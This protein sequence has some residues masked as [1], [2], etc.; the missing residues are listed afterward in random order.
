M[1]HP[2][3]SRSLAPDG[4]CRRIKTAK[5]TRPSYSSRTSIVIHTTLSVL[6]GKPYDTVKAWNGGRSP[7]ESRPREM[8]QAP[9]LLLFSEGV[10]RILKI[11]RHTNRQPR[12]RIFRLARSHFSS[13]WIAALWI[14]TIAAT[15][16]ADCYDPA[17]Q[18]ESPFW[19]PCPITG[20]K[21]CCAF[22]N[23]DLCT[24]GGLCLNGGRYWRD[25]CTDPTWQDPGCVKLCLCTLTRENFSQK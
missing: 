20:T 12:L 6:K 7:L 14:L 22:G 1:A 18:D 3:A 16:T 11:G 21:M 24:A 23:G 4:C 8:A 13:T 5:V 17:G 25:G 9:P 10:G 2:T 19:S 15:V